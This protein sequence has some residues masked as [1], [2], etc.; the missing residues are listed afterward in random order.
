[1]LN[2]LV[3]MSLLAAASQSPESPRRPPKRRS[4]SPWATTGSIIA[5]QALS[6]DA[7]S[8]LGDV[9]VRRSR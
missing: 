4:S 7:I 5:A 8:L 9:R 3:L 1:M 6:V 2:G